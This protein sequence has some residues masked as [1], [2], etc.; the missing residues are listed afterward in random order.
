M[1]P[2]ARGKSFELL[3]AESFIR[4]ESTL[5]VV[6]EAA[7]DDVAARL[8]GS[9]V[10]NG[11]AIVHCHDWGRWMPA[12]AGAEPWPCRV[13]EVF[14]ARLAGQLLALDPALA[15]LL[16]CRIAVHGGDGVTTVTTPMP[17]VLMTEFS[18]AAEVARVA[19]SF[20]AGLQRV[21]RGL[22]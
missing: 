19:K 1:N 9:V 2:P 6:C 14:D 16:P 5:S 8:E 7:F 20:E 18:H 15:H 17:S 11:M 22:L 3:K 10:A 21:L 13:Y 4:G 12:D